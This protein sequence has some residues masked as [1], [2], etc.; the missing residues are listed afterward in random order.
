MIYIESKENNL[1]KSTKKLKERRFRQKEG[2]F[3][4]EGLRL[5]EE[6]VK[7]NMEIEFIILSERDKDI[8]ESSTLLK[9]FIA[10]DKIFVLEKNLFSQL[11][12]TEN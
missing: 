7:A 12:S 10:E 1:F 4:L 9:E 5:I 3:I 2:K 8:L 6:A 11:A